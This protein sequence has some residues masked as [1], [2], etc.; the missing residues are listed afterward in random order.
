MIQVTTVMSEG[1]E[2]LKRTQLLIA[3]AC[4]SLL[5]ACSPD[6]AGNV[7]MKM[8][9][10]NNR[11]CTAA[12][13]AKGTQGALAGGAR[14]AVMASE[15]LALAANLEGG[16]A[17]GADLLAKGAATA[18]DK[19]TDS[20]I[21]DTGP[22]A[23]EK[24][25]IGPGAGEKSAKSSGAGSGAG[26]GPTSAAGLSAAPT[27]E[28]AK[29]KPLSTDVAGAQAASAGGGGGAGAS[30]GGGGAFNSFLGSKDSGA[31]GNAE[32]ETF[33]DASKKGEVDPMGTQDPEDYFT[34]SELGDNIFKI[35]EKRYRSTTSGWVAIQAREIVGRPIFKGSPGAGGKGN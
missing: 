20:Q 31:N 18:S 30:S 29:L 28:F 5:S 7:D 34:R 10:G 9:S 13:N 14:S 33:G 3:L 6:K 15:N 27:G 8:P 2:L 16:R 1:L 25:G 35:V 32:D 23:A 21:A 22:L 26:G 4:I 19:T 12:S 24:V 17:A 11:C